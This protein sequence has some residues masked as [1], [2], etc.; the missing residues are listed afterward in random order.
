MDAPKIYD[1]DPETIISEIKARYEDGLGKSILPAQPEMQGVL[2][3]AYREVLLRALADY[4][5]SQILT[6]TSNAPVLDYKA[7]NFG[8]TRL[9]ATH[10]VTKLK[11]I[12]QMPHGTVT[13]FAGSK[14]S[15][16]D[17]EID[18]AT[19]IE[20]VATSEATFIEVDATALLPGLSA[21]GRGVGE[22]S[23]IIDPYP[24]VVSVSNTTVSAG[25]ATQESD[26]GL[27]Q[28][29]IQAPSGFSTAGPTGAYKFHARSATPA[30]IDVEVT[31]GGA[32]I[33]NIYPLVGGGIQT[34]QAI[35][36]AVYA[37]CNAEDVRPLNDIVN[38][39]APTRL[40]YVIPLNIILKYGAI[41]S[42]TVDKVLEAIKA[43]C[44]LK[45]R[46]LGANITVSQ[47]INAGMNEDVQEIYFDSF[48]GVAVPPTSFAVCTAV[49]L[50]TVT[51][52]DPNA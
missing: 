27:R 47:I 17:G 21:N 11:Y 30:I 23:N 29:L 15:T 12:L 33:V 46:K 9:A 45:S 4:A 3:I 44:V 41:Q 36:D 13:I 43:Y 34:P 7:S 6:R 38:V 20:V 10:A 22:I 40:E 35:L 52:E 37:K 39:I 49:S 32:G 24:F 2:S 5:L 51:Y 42:T 16:S 19:D 8:V 28:R 18:F 25:G 31:N 50:G 1:K 48:S 26:E 14:V